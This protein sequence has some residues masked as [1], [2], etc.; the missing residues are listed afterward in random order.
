MF[1]LSLKQ[2]T[3]VWHTLCECDGFVEPLLFFSA[4]GKSENGEGG[5]A[6]DDESEKEQWEEDQRVTIHP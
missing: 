2:R 5:I 6:F 1:G 3:Q 4:T